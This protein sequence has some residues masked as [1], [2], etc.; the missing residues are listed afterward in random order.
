LAVEGALGIARCLTQY[1]ATARGPARVYHNIW[2]VS[3]DDDGR[4]SDYT[5]YYMKE[6]TEETA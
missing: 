2:I 5:E 4:C 3:L 6:P 1:R